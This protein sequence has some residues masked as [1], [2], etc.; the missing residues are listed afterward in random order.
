MRGG[1]DDVEEGGV[2]FDGEGR[3]KTLA[4]VNVQW[5]F[6]IYIFCAIGMALERFARTLNSGLRYHLAD[7]PGFACT[8]KS[9]GRNGGKAKW[10][11]ME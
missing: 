10:K 8:M 5:P 4:L 7:D 11:E 6:V 9:N 3:S 1:G 2:G